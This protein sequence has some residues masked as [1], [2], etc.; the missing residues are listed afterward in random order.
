MASMSEEERLKAE[1]AKLSGAI[2]THKQQH[3]QPFSG[4][5]YAPR[6]RGHYSAASTPSYRGAYTG[7]RG[8]FHPGA[9]AARG[10]GRGAAAIPLRNRT[11]ILNDSSSK[12]AASATASTISTIDKPNTV[13]A[14]TAASSGSVT[15][16]P[17]SSNAASSAAAAAGTT[18]GWIKR[19]S[20]HNMSLVST[21]TFQRTE[22]ARLAAM[23]ATRKAK[24]QA[25]AAAAA[26]AS[27]SS[28]SGKLA[29]RGKSAKPSS[30]VRRGDNMG[31]VVI[32]GVVFEFDPSGTKLVKKP[33]QPSSSENTQS[34]A[35]ASSASAAGAST[36]AAVPLKTSINGQDY[37]RTKRGNLISAELLAKRK[38]QR[39]AQ[40]K[41]GRLDKMVGQISAMQATRNASARANKAR[42]RTLDVKKARTLCT[43]FNKTGQCKRGLSCPYLHDSSKIALC[44]KVLRPAGCTLPK[45]TCPLSHTPR[46][47]RVP[48]CVHYLRSGKCRNGDE[49]LYTH[50]DKLPNGL[51]TKICRDF[52]DYGW[53]ERGKD[54]SERHTYEC[55]DFV[56]KG[57]CER[58]G[59]K[60]VHVIR[61]SQPSDPHLG[62]PEHE[63]PAGGGVQ[64]GDLFMRDDAAAAEE[65]Q[66]EHHES[67]R[68]GKRKR[69]LM[70]TELD[71]DQLL[72]P[73]DDDDDHDGQEED[74]EQVNFA[75]A[76]DSRKAKRRKAKAFTQQKDFISFD[77]D[78][79]DEEEAEDDE[80][81]DES[82]MDGEV[83]DGDEDEQEGLEAGSV[84]SEDFELS[85]G[86]G[87]EDEED[88]EGEKDEGE[89]EKDEDE[90]E[91]ED[92]DKEEEEEI[93]AHSGK[94]P[95]HQGD[96]DDDDDLVD[97]DL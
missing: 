2:Q 95:A 62:A 31:E 47:E 75:N 59:C 10:R 86:G 70:Q 18:D 74:D 12:G 53:C 7:G 23:E 45:G 72:L 24:A 32:D 27:S 20:T 82:E 9:S 58:K 69:P 1:I 48:H 65:S 14:A 35:A 43:F 33:I 46:P 39:E 54:C 68:T 79:D 13:D 84:H 29:V 28:T 41:M 25:K 4:G 61:A 17:S 78:V 94:P 30:S 36:S 40:A 80:E 96:D 5:A 83:S 88:E 42:S 51:A 44:P 66:D 37:I 89:D 67:S 56:E 16:S 49:C 97:R 26:A 77:D 22:P 90:D 3:H 93:I 34:T 21:S 55:P 11:L 64:D 91:G 87:E 52:S 38:A 76:H 19:K 92:Q 6:G 8:G 63:E 60:L 15:S 73:E 81:D 57:K 71:D 85:D 50:S